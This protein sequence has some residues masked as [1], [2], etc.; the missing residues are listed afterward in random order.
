[1]LVGP[2][3]KDATKHPP[4]RRKVTKIK[5]YL[6]QVSIALRLRNQSKGLFFL[7]LESWRLRCGRDV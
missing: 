2:S 6:V 4:V 5:S 3:G 7:K 1:M